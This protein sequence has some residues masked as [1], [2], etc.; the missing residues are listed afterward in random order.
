VS[1]I[2][3]YV[4][5]RQHPA[6]P[7]RC[8]ERAPTRATAEALAAGWARQG[9]LATVTAGVEPRPAPATRSGRSSVTLPAAPA[10]A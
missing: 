4:W 5:V 6:H 3:W 9:F 10:A 7:Y 8:P 2:I 1:A